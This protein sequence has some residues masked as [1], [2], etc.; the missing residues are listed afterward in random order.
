MSVLSN[1]TL[2]LL[3]DIERRIDPETEED[4]KKQWEDFLYDKF[5]GDVF[6]LNRKKLAPPAVPIEYI[7]INDALDDYDMMMRYELNR[8]SAALNHPGHNLALRA[9]YGSA[10]LASLFGPE[11]FI[12]PRDMN[13]LPTT[14]PFNDTDKIIELIG[15]GIPDLYA[16][17]GRKVFE[18]GELAKETFAKYPKIS[19]YVYVYHP[20][21][22]GP[23]DICELL[24][25]SDMFYAMY[26][27]PELVHSAMSLITETYKAM[28]DKWFE[29]YPCDSHMNP[30]WPTLWHKGRITLRCD[31]AMNLSPELYDEYAAPYDA[32]LLDYF[33]G[34][35]M[36][37]C[38]RGDHYIETLCSQKGLC[39]IQLGQ[40]ELNDM[41]KIFTASVDKGVKILAMGRRSYEDYKDRAVRFNHSLHVCN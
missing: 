19:K 4:F 26:D 41:E 5:D 13:T 12:M 38:G 2:A 28:L 7:N 15:K 30:H 37:F 24:W 17:F 29:M 16:G 11:L 14:R 20:D 39:G 6:T 40:P 21:V 36:H 35:C 22:Q 9:N 27:E 25:G 33:E 8:V 31:S 18:F 3:D 10:I 1:T 32:K 34:G 23:L